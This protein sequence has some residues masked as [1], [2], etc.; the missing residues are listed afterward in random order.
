MFFCENFKALLIDSQLKKVYSEIAWRT[1]V[2]QK[3]GSPKKLD[4]AFVEVDALASVD[5]EI[6]W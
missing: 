5:G 4:G 2:V 1:Q 6:P 3:V